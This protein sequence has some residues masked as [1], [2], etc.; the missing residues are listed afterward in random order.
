MALSKWL[1]LW[2]VSELDSILRLAVLRNSLGKAIDA[3]PDI[4]QLQEMLSKFDYFSN[5]FSLANMQKVLALSVCSS[6][7]HLTKS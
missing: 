2:F 7:E 1:K 6:G 4:H 5:F 3:E